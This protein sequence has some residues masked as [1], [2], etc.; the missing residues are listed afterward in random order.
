MI[1]KSS[2][3]IKRGLKKNLPLLKDGQLAYCKDA[4]ELW[5]GNDGTNEQI[6]GSSSNNVA[7]EFIQL[8]SPNGTIFK[9]SVNDDGELQV[10]KLINDDNN[11][12]EPQEDENCLIA[13]DGDC[14]ITS[15]GDN[16]IH[17]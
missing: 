12:E 7:A 9:V 3:Q 6:C 5:I 1:K 16:F 4:K 14:L 8:V 15:D 2:I 11:N 13:S 10:T 17:N